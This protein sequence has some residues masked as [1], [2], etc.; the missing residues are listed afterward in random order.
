MNNEYN[1]KQSIKIQLIEYI[2]T[3]NINWKITNN[4]PVLYT[5]Y[6]YDNIIGFEKFYPYYQS[7]SKEEINSIPNIMNLK[8][9]ISRSYNIE[10]LK[11]IL[12][13]PI[14]FS[15]MAQYISELFRKIY[16]NHNSYYNKDDIKIYANM[17]LIFMNNKVLSNPYTYIIN[18]IQSIKQYIVYIK[19]NSVINNSYYNT[20]SKN[21]RMFTYINSHFNYE[22]PVSNELK[23]TFS[24]VFPTEENI[25][26]EQ[27]KAELIA[28]LN[29]IINPVPI[30]KI[31]SKNSKKVNN[32][33]I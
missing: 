28:N 26:I 7:L 11:A 4:I 13:L 1:S 12:M 29:I 31:K 8:S 6:M 19:K 2:M 5:F 24:M 14:D 17:F 30:I 21:I 32:I 23:E 10:Q 27:E 25:N 18:E 3:K 15:D 22:I 16:Q 33:I 20:Y 9:Y